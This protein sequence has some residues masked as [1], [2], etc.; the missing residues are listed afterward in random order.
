M[1]NLSHKFVARSLDLGNPVTLYGPDYVNSYMGMP[2]FEYGKFFVLLYKHTLSERV[3]SLLMSSTLYVTSL[4]PKEGEL[5]FV[6]KVPDETYR[7]VFQPFI[8]GK[9]SEV[10]RS[11]VELHFPNDPASKLYGNRL[12]FDKSPIMRAKWEEALD[13]TLPDEA[14]VW[15]KPKRENE[16]Y[17]FNQ[18]RQNLV[19]EI[20][21]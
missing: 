20:S 11:Y 18:E 17:E 10:D 4:C 6:F 15:S 21:D 12:V 1:R 9:Y 16:Y 3:S 5:L 7:K 8:K 19:L 2:G 14:E 13:V